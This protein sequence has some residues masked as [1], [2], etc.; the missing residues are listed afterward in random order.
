MI[1]L[2]A[3]SIRFGH[4]RFWSKKNSIFDFKPFITNLALSSLVKDFFSSNQ[5]RALAFTYDSTVLHSTH[6]FTNID[7]FLQDSILEELMSCFKKKKKKSNER[8]ISKSLFSV[9]SKITS[10]LQFKN[11]RRKKFFYIRL[12]N[13]LLT[14]LIFSGNTNFYLYRTFQFYI[15]RKIFKSEFFNISF[16]NFKF[17]YDFHLFNPFSCI[18]PRIKKNCSPNTFKQLS[19]RNFFLFGFQRL[20][21][22]KP[23]RRRSFQLFQ[24]APR[25]HFYPIIHY[26]FFNSVSS[27]RY[28]LFSFFSKLFSS[29]SNQSSP[30]Y[31]VRTYPVFYLDTNVNAYAFYS[32]VRLKY[33]Y[34]LSHVIKP[35]ING[36]ARYYKGFFIL[37]NGRF[38]RAQIASTKIFRRGFVNFSRSHIPLYYKIRT[39]PLRYGASTIHLW[40]HH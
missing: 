5:F 38:T 36:I 24:L 33:K 12:S 4:S 17:F 30:I 19:C 21:Q 10:P 27:P 2:K 31:N 23:S 18:Y 7:V 22:I 8:K 37:C 32:I 34:I 11:Q 16:S 35:I 15:N 20:L 9:F 28:L 14:N 29:F 13:P 6:I 26:F 3:Q 25:L 40:L 1:N 39:I